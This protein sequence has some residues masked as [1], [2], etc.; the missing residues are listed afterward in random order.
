MLAATA[1]LAS[2]C[3]PERASDPGAS[4][5]ISTPPATAGVTPTPTPSATRIALPKDCRA[6]LS[7]AV[8]AQLGTTP[9]NDAGFG[10]DAG[11]QPDGSLHCI[12]GSPATDTG[13][14][15]TEISYADRGPT[16]DM[17]NELQNAQGFTCFTP[18]GGTRCEK[19]WQDATY[20]VTDGRTLFWRDGVLIDTRYAALA[21]EG[22]TSSIV[23]ALWPAH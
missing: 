23:A 10:A 9:L 16:L 12:W 3:V 6:I 15:V 4:T 11:I 21:P 17:L 7:P 8:L 5:H 13:R 19:T 1:L 2:G 22:Y 18:D 20:P 14:L